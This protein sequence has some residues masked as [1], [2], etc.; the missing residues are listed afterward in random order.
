MDDVAASLG[1]DSVALFQRRFA[2]GPGR[3]ANGA[4]R[5]TPSCT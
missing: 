5:A 3:P 1:Y 4:A 2:A